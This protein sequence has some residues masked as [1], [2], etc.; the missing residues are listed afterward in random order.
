V[1]DAGRISPGKPKRVPRA[2]SVAE[3]RQLRAW[4]SNDTRA[5]ELDLPDLVDMLLAT[6]LRVGEALA[7]T[8]DAV[9]LSAA[10]V[11]VRGTV[12]R[13]KGRGLMI[14]P[15]PKTRA[16]FR[17]LVLPS[18]AVE[19]LKLRPQGRPDQT[20]SARSRAAYVTATM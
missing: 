9:D 13:V 8:W 20:Q 3:I 12:I 6:G 11:E 1:R 15:A 10:T 14:K 5:P 19:M 18:W 4:L 7:V 16:G 17:T 2:L